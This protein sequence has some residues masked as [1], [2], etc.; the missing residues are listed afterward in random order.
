MMK[1]LRA[2]MCVCL[3]CKMAAGD[4]ALW[5][6]GWFCL[7]PAEPPRRLGRLV[8]KSG[9][10]AW[11]SFRQVPLARCRRC[12][13]SL[14]ALICIHVRVASVDFSSHFD[15]CHEVTDKLNAKR[16]KPAD[17][18]NLCERSAFILINGAATHPPL[19][20]K[21]EQLD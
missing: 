12:Q 4:H 7:H 21:W 18:Q 16:D 5:S 1:R 17:A 2:P 14:R 9:L 11:L 3:A 13:R 15:S 19:Q 8:K 10:T 6:S 20:E